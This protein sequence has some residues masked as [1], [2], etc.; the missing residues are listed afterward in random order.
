M[1]DNK[2]RKREKDEEV[3]NLVQIANP[4]SLV[5]G[6]RQ[7]HPT[8]CRDVWQRIVD[9]MTR[10]R[11]LCF[12]TTI[13]DLKTSNNKLMDEMVNIEKRRREEEINPA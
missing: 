13:Y 7:S 11:A 10:L 2:W 12:T 8:P 1:N 9:S 6:R 4:N 5:P 3:L